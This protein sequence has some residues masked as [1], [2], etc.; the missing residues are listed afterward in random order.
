MAPPSEH[1]FETSSH[2]LKPKKSL[3]ENWSLLGNCPNKAD[4]KRETLFHF[5]ARLGLTKFVSLLLN[6]HGAR[7]CLSIPNRHGELASGLVE[8]RQGTSSELYKIL[9]SPDDIE[10]NRLLVSDVQPI[11]K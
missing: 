2:L 9:S 7:K 5:G 10:T 6:F 3:P 11:G 8:E 4:N 1:Q